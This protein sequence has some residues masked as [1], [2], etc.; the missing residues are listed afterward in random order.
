MQGNLGVPVDAYAHA[1]GFLRSSEIWWC[2][3]T[4]RVLHEPVDLAG[5]GE[6]A[7]P[8]MTL[9]KDEKQKYQ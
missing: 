9:C 1:Q 4:L 5:A 3:G 7:I 2:K 6:V 8:H